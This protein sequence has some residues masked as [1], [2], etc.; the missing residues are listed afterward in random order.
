MARKTA[1]KTSTGSRGSSSSRPAGR[2]LPKAASKA[3][4]KAKGDDKARSKP[5]KAAAPGKRTIVAKPAIAPVS[6]KPVVAAKTAPK[7]TER[8]DAKTNK[9]QQAAPSAAD[10]AKKGGKGAAAPAKTTDA[11]TGRTKPAK[12]GGS[13]GAEAA[14]AVTGPLAVI[15]KLAKMQKSGGKGGKKTRTVAEAATNIVAD[16]KGYVFIN[17]RRVRMISTKGAA[18]LKKPRANGQAA[19]EAAP[20]QIAIKSIKTK[21]SKKELNHYRELLLLKRRELIGDL[22][23]METEAL[24]SGSGNLSH[25]PIHMAD[26]GTDVNDQDLM[27][28]LA[29]TE[30]G[31]LREIDAALHRIDDR[32]YGVCQMTGKPIPKARLDAKPW[33]KYSIEAARKL[34]G[35][36]R[37]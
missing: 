30:R 32:S 4:P 8:V 6:K 37:H 34:E 17:G 2:A 19:A 5:V 9:S 29:E 28:G 35:Q 1:G 22:H 18:P 24:R 14:P 15:Q 12:A 23:A 7:A 16:A 13:E 36:W 33:A 26:I 25:M 20:E 3:K 21:L 10:G 27:L 31:Q 11:A